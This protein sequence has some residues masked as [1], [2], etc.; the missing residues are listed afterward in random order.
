MLTSISPSFGDPNARPP[1]PKRTQTPVLSSPLLQTPKQTTSSS[2]FDDTSGWTPRF[3]EEYSVFNSTPGNLR[4][5]AS[6][7]DFSNLFAPLSPVPQTIGKKRSHSTEATTFDIAADAN[8]LSA[9]PAPLATVTRAPR[10]P[11][12]LEQLSSSHKDAVTDSSN[13]T[14]RASH[15]QAQQGHRSAKKPRT[16]SASSATGK[17]PL[18]ARSQFQTATPPPSSKGGRK[19]APKPQASSMQNQAFPQPD[20]SNAP[21]QQPQLN[22]AFVTGNPDDVFGY[23]M[24]P[25][26][27]PPV[28]GQRPFWGFDLDTSGMS[29]DVDLSAAGA[30]L[31]QS[32]AQNQAH[33]QMNSVDWGSANQM[34]QQPGMAAQSNSQTQQ[35]EQTHPSP[36][37]QNQSLQQSQSARHVRPLAPKMANMSTPNMQSSSQ[38]FNFG[39]YQ[40]SMNT[41]SFTASPGGVDPGILFSHQPLSTGIDSNAMTMPMSMSMDHFSQPTSSAPANMEKTPT[42]RNAESVAPR[43]SVSTGNELLQS[44][45]QSSG[46]GSGQS[47]VQQRKQVSRSRAISPTKNPGRPNLSRSFSESARGGKRTVGG[48]RNPLPTL[49]PARPV[50]V[51]QPNLPPPPASQGNNWVQTQG[52]PSSGRRSPLKLSQHH[53]LSSLTSIPENVCNLLAKSRQAKRTSVKFVIDENGRARAETIA[54]EDDEQ[55]SEAGNEPTLP[56]SKVSAQRNSWAGPLSVSTPIPIDDEEYSSSS[57]DEPIII[58]SR[59]TSFN[60]PDPPKSSGTASSRPP[61]TSSMVSQNRMRH[62]SFSDRHPFRPSSHLDPDHDAMD[63]DP[64]QQHHQHQQPRPS[65]GGSLGDAAAE[66]RKVMQAENLRRPTS[67]QQPPP[68]LGSTENSGHR[69]QFTPG[70]RSS[71]STISEA[72][73]PAT[74]PNQSQEQSQVRCVCNRPDGGEGVYM[75]KW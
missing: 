47:Q 63:V 43:A 9:A 12:S 5:T 16:A 45:G 17:S 2:H 59:T 46:S 72:S 51:H 44:E 21:P 53:R 3:A 54:G 67:G 71:S 73:L 35:Q 42:M 26:T 64:P 32:P 58:P 48:N 15:A 19:L 25:A 8:Q 37:Q 40:M 66:L 23:P 4:G 75:V 55:D 6:G 61:T 34:F 69:Q 49:A 7:A 39:Q 29:I 11:S 1:T 28:A 52:G 18:L 14:S 30:D 60:Y 10:L 31:F 36:Q 33:R 56:I 57:D 38:D 70:Q 62:R 74:S 24:G 20:F 41:N 27:A 65:T 68:P 50:T 22:T 13:A